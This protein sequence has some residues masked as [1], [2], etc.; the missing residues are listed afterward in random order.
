[1]KMRDFEANQLKRADTLAN[2]AYVFCLL[3]IIGLLLAILS[4]TTVSVAEDSKYKKNIMHKAEWAFALSIIML[5]VCATL[6]ICGYVQMSI[7]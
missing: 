5:C 1:M 6:I 3:P 2:W 7:Q 4:L